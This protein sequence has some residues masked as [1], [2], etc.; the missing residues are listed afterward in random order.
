MR[1]IKFFIFYQNL[2]L[3]L[4][5]RSN[6]QLIM[7][8][9]GVFQYRFSKLS[10]RVLITRQMADI[11]QFMWKRAWPKFQRRCF[12]LSNFCVTAWKA[13]LCYS[14]IYKSFCKSIENWL[15]YATFKSSEHFGLTYFLRVT[16]NLEGWLNIFLKRAHQG[17]HLRKK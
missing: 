5:S 6:D 16:C 13:L 9:Q 10:Y 3:T 2:T 11:S 17:I 12:D 15:G 8:P 7:S 1:K 4:R 14:R